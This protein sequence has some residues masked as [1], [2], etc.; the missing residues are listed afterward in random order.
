M[1]TRVEFTDDGA[2]VISCSDDDTV[3]VWDI[4]SGRRV[5]KLAGNMFAFVEGPPQEHKRGRHVLTASD[6]MLLIYE[7]EKAQP[8]PGGGEGAAPVAC[9]KA[10][11][12]IASVQCRG[13]A[14]C[15]VCKGGAVCGLSALFLAA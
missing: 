10:P 3:C 15:V 4:A 2:Q 8:H 6:D 1:V 7:V 12:R 14:I 5:R 9:F 11:Q 13:T